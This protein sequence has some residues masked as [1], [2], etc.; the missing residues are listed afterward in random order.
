MRRFLFLSGR[1]SLITLISLFIGSCGSDE[2]SISVDTSRTSQNSYTVDAP[3]FLKNKTNTQNASSTSTN[4]DS[5]NPKIVSQSAEQTDC[6]EAYGS[7]DLYGNLCAK[8]H[9]VI[10]GVKK[11]TEVY[12]VQEITDVDGDWSDIEPGMH[13]H[14]TWGRQMSLESYDESSK[15]ATYGPYKSPGGYDAI[16]L[17]ISQPDYS[18][19]VRPIIILDCT[20]KMAL[21]KLRQNIAILSCPA[22]D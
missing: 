5:G 3:E 7:P 21:I 4:N 14:D 17:W 15:T 20:T 11:S 6:Q 2:H 9:V 16:F 13:V 22:D 18:G 1:I 19:T 12:V 10:S 8:Y